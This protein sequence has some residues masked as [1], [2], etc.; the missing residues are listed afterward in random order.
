MPL[1]CFEASAPQEHHFWTCPALQYK[2]SIS[3]N[4]HI[5]F[6]IMDQYYTIEF[7]YLHHGAHPET[8]IDAIDADDSAVGLGFDSVEEPEMVSHHD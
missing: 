3:G 6:D 1:C 2:F 4:E 7:D 8:A 5:D